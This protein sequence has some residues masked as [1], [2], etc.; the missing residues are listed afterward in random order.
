MSVKGMFY[1]RNKAY[2]SE[3]FIEHVLFLPVLAIE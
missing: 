3:R 2:T 1:S